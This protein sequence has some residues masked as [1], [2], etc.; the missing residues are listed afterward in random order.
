MHYSL[1]G[2]SVHGIL[3][4]RILEWVATES[5]SEVAQSCL[6]L[7]NPMDN[8]LPG[9]TIHGIFQARV[10]EWGAISY[11]RRSSQSRD[12]TQV[13]HMVGI[14]GRRFT[15]WATRED[16]THR[17]LEQNRKP[18]NESLFVRSIIYNKGNKNTQWGK[19]ACSTNGAGK[20]GRLHAKQ[21]NW[22]IFSYYM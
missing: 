19:T 6:T 12:W 3:Q 1:P 2:S 7:C 8:S 18:I 11:S 9:S 20:I 21:P 16:D 17:S 4:A 15:I 10:L 5:E 13:S 14:V 22:T